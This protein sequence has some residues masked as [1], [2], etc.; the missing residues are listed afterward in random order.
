MEE[1]DLK[2]LP[3]GVENFEKITTKKYYYVDKTWFIKELLDKKGEVNLFTRPRRFGKSL[4]ISMFQHFFD[5]QY[6][7]KKH[8]FNG[9]RIMEAGE[10]YLQHQNAYP[11][12]K[13]TF[14]N[15][16]GASFESAFI[17]LRREIAREYKR[18][19]YVLESPKLL[20]DDKEQFKYFRKYQKIKD[21]EGEKDEEREERVIRFSKEFK[22]SLL[23]LSECLATYHDKKVVVLIDE[24]DVPLEKAHFNKYYEPMI[25]LVRGIFSQGLKSNDVVDFA[26]LTGCLRVSKESIFTG[27]NNPDIITTLS[28]RYSEYFGFTQNEV[29]EMLSYYDLSH[30]L[31]EM[32]DWY[33]G[34]L[35]GNR[36]VYNP[37]S[38]IKYVS[39]HQDDEPLAESYWA[40]TSS[41]SIVKELIIHADD[42]ARD[43]LEHLIAGGTITK[44]INE[45]VVY[46]EILDDADN[47][48]NFLYFTGYLTKV[49]KKQKG[50]RNYF[51]LSIPN[52]EV[53][54][55]YE[56]K[57]RE[58]FNK[59]VKETDRTTLYRAILEQDVLTFEDEVIELLADSISY[60][61]SQENFYHDFLTGI[62]GGL[63]GYRVISNRES[64]NGRGD[65]FIKPRD[66]R[67]AA[68]IIE[69]KVAKSAQK[70]VSTCDEALVQIET[71][72]YVDELWREGYSET[73]KY[74]IAF[75]RKAC[76]IKV[77]EQTKM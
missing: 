52:K 40:N 32:Q 37:W 57:I 48:W 68:I 33:N 14:K 26:V 7:D 10:Q 71:K 24:Y 19:S 25:D 34:Y 58:W 64:G 76:R 46:A 36:I 74:G 17:G 30:K 28:D 39:D 73:I 11:V 16:D 38:A 18:H 44:P 50:V 63:K 77:A 8:V 49:G 59:R 29:E 15:A 27:F 47:L 5:M 2:A 62:L 21:I 31:T 3:T 53:L 67:K 70:M 35:F 72:N 22:S 13:M 6:A 69:V 56:K 55:I 54:S 51:E 43:E 9:L 42:E 66:Y 23:F 41:N 1:A 75:Y 45:D 12:I 4:A 61:D 20:E 65:I 60:M